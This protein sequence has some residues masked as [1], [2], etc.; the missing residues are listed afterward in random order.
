MEQWFVIFALCVMAT[1][2]A[3]MIGAIA[4]LGSE[5]GFSVQ[6]EKVEGAGIRW[7]VRVGATRV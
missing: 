1:L 2:C 3:M 7:T 4:L 6:M 5:T